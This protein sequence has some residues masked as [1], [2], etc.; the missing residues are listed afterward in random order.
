M[1]ETEPRL[2]R[3]ETAGRML[4]ISESA[5]RRLVRQGE[6]RAIKIF[7][8]LRIPVTEIDALIARKLAETEANTPASDP[9]VASRRST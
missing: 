1:E 4:G 6:V 8:D 3:L 5:V 9:A 7:A 2:A